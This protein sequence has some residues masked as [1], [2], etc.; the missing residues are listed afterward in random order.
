MAAKL[1]IHACWRT[2]VR[3]KSLPALLCLGLVIFVASGCHRIPP[4][5]MAPLFNAGMSYDS[6]HQLTALHVT[7]AE[8][9][10][11]ATARQAGLS[12]AGCIA[13]VKLFHDRASPFNAGDSVASMLGAGMSEE[14]VIEIC[15]LDQLGLLAGELEAIRLVGLPDSLVLEVA[16]RHSEGKPVLSGASLGRMKN[17]GIRE[18]TLSQLI[19]RGVPDSQAEAILS[20][21][22]RGMSD[23]KILRNFTGS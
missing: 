21:R 16:R 19:E 7:D 1:R 18:S 23:A 15:K 8:V 20:A 10:Q 13:L 12:D 5:D 4:V 14:T 2:A 11:I 17:A 6:V 3:H 9:A 22:R